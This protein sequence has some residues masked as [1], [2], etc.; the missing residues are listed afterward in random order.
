MTAQRCYPVAQIW[1]RYHPLGM[2]GNFISRNLACG[3]N[4]DVVTHDA[5]IRSVKSLQNITCTTGCSITA[6]SSGRRQNGNNCYCTMLPGHIMRWTPVRRGLNCLAWMDNQIHAHLPD[7]ET[8]FG[9]GGLVTLTSLSRMRCHVKPDG[10]CGCPPR[11]RVLS[12]FVRCA[13]Y[14]PLC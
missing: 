14:A 9:C 4:A 1:R 7:A 10:R 11:N 6:P 3:G 13:L 8:T 5:R 12:Q 2:W